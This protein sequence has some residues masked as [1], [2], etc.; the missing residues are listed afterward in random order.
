MQSALEVTERTLAEMLEGLAKFTGDGPGVTRL[1]Y[2]P[3]WREAHR[4]LHGRA[5]SLG[6]AAPPTRRAISSSTI[7][8]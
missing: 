3:A 7:R 5:A 1:A 6:L 4:W 8:C 2:D